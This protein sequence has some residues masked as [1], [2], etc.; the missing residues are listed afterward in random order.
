MFAYLHT[1]N[2]L[3]KQVGTSLLYYMTENKLNI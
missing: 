1:Y 3:S 2:F